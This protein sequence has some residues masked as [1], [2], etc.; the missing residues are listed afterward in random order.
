MKIRLGSIRRTKKGNVVADLFLFEDVEGIKFRLYMRR[1]G[2]V[3]L[4]FDTTNKG[5]AKL[6][7][8]LLKRAGVDAKVHHKGVW[9]I[10]A[11]LR[12]LAGADRTLKE[13][14]VAL[15]KAA[16]EAG[17]VDAKKAERWIAKIE[18]MRIYNVG[19]KIAIYSKYPEVLEREAHLLREIGLIEG[20][21]FTLKMPEDGKTGRLRILARGMAHIAWLSVHGSEGQ[22]ELAKEFLE[23]VL[24][25]AQIEGESAY[26]RVKKIIDGSISRSFVTLRGLEKRV[27]VSGK[28]CV[29][30]VKEGTAWLED[31]RL[32]IAV[33]AEVDGIETKYEVSFVKMKK[34]GVAGFV[35]ADTAEDAERIAVVIKAVTGI[36]PTVVRMNNGAYMLRCNE[37]H[38][39]A[40]IRYAELA[41]VV[42]KWLSN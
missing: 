38:L 39:K 8:C 17:W 5:R 6:A 25:A 22:R 26:R 1:C 31:G 11:S 40:L 30:K 33:A 32:K 41:D 36:S 7:L 35:R 42:E 2:D 13:A 27:E 9:H 18:G 29:V 4:R 10:F 16:S 24:R 21:H 3:V 37:K 19:E 15:I 14:V 20:R 12:G 23:R 34:G 28:E